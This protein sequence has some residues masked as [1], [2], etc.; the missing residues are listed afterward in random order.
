M[1]RAK[2]VKAMGNWMIQLPQ[3]YFSDCTT[4]LVKLLLDEVSFEN[5]GDRV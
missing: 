4:C 1:L 5:N 3:V 2:N